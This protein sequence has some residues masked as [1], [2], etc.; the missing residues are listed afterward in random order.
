MNADNTN[1]YQWHDF[2]AKSLDGNMP[3]SGLAENPMRMTAML[4]MQSPLQN[5]HPTGS[6]DLRKRLLQGYH[7]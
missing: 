1:I 5:T 6:P 3:D 2:Q 7:G 4:P